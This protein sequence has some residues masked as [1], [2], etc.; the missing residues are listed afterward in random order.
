MGIAMLFALATSIFNNANNSQ[1]EK[2]RAQ[3]QDFLDNSPFKANKDLTRKERKAMGLPPN[4]FYEQ[5][6]DLTL[7]PSTGRPMTERLFQLQ[8]ELRQQQVNR[9]GAGDNTQPWID[10]GPNDQGGRTRGI[11]F[12]PNDIGNANPADDYTR[13]F[14][15]G[16]SGGLWVNDDI[17]DASSP[18][19]LV[20]GVDSNIAVTVI[21]PDPSD[22]KT[23]YIGSGESYTSGDA[24]GRGI[25]KTTDSGA[26]WTNIFGGF[27]NTSGQF[28]NGIF[29]IND[30]VVRDN[31]GSTE[32]YAAVAGAFF[33]NGIGFNQWHGLNEMGLYKSI[34]GGANWS[35]FAIQHGDG[36]F[37]NPNDI[38]I[39]IDNNIWF[40]TTSNSFGNPGGD[41][42][43][44]TDGITFTLEETIPNAA[45]TELEVSQNDADKFW[46]AANVSG[47]AA[48]YTTNNAFTT[49]TTLN[50]PNDL[51]NGIPATDYTRGQAF[52]DLPI[53]ADA[54]DNLYV[55]GI[56]L[57]RSTNDGTS[58]TQLSKWSN[59]NNL[60]TLNNFVHA[61]Q[62]A[63]VFRPGNDNQAALGCDG[64]VF[65]I[66]DA[67]AAASNTPGSIIEL[68]NGYNTIQFY[69]GSIDEV[70]GADGDDL[71]G[72]TQDNGTQFVNDGSPGD[73]PYVD[74]VGG[75]GGYTEI[76]GADGYAITTYPGNNSRYVP[77]PTL[78]FPGTSITTVTI[79][80]GGDF[81][82][83]VELDKN[84]DILY[85]NLS[86]GPN[87]T[88]GLE[89]VTEFIPGG[90]PRAN[91]LLGSGILTNRPSALK[92]SPYTTTSTT[93]YVG[94]RDGTVWRVTNANTGGGTWTNITGPAF[95]GSVSA[96]E[97]GQSESEIFVT[98]FN[99]GIESIWYSNDAGVTWTSKQGDLPD[100]PVYCILQNPIL[101]S[102][103]IIGT[104]LGVWGTPDITT[105]SPQW[106]QLYNG[107]RDVPVLDLDVRPSDNIVLAS[108]H[109]RG[110]FTS[111]FTGV[112][113]SVDTNALS[114]DVKIFPTVS[115][116]NIKVRSLNNLG[117]A[118]LEVYNISGQKVFTDAI[119]LNSYEN[120]IS[121]N[122]SSGIYMV[123]ISGESFTKTQ[124]IIIK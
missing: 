30:L 95:V 117:Q 2:L 24:I 21:V 99:Y 38:E 75:D 66:T 72:G 122:I 51:D 119:D 48:L 55:G 8:S 116:G 59:N 13:V 92:V 42:Y 124:K 26:T 39:D 31:A 61:D 11:M 43:K 29:Y 47:Q 90:P 65:F 16:V 54:N 25:W 97:L 84:L 83:Q 5:M 113:L 60:V 103:V 28:I 81:I 44:S 114:N 46:V 80:G 17:T 68:N 32:L 7:D 91:Q 3:H 100:L 121:L 94:Q 105:A 96:I 33:G 107:M 77:I 120:G 35:R 58:W 23:F 98:M 110:F 108:T 37:K 45:R 10:R 82:N 70:D 104:P 73:N 18:W 40:T 62:H 87:A 64:G 50:E 41:I 4:A 102:E 69:Y 112:P 101:P 20:Q 49:R 86:G 63:V 109:G 78:P 74:P 106:V 22:T 36:S 9:G 115:N 71:A 56:N 85:A 57:F 79:G 12:D 14:A 67:N 15:G 6:W 111:Q 88:F 89:R 93:L 52:Y 34:D 53:E 123:K 76:D 118:S 19:T 27:D 1:L